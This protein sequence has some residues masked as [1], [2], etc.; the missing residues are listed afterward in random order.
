MFEYVFVSKEEE[1]LEAQR[2]FNE[3]ALWLKIDLSFQNFEEELASLRTMYAE[4]KGCILLCKHEKNPVACVAVRSKEK[5]IAELKRMYVQ[6]AF[7]K[8]GIGD[9]LLNMA[10]DFS[11]K[12]GYKKIRL[13]TLDT[14]IP[15][16]GLYEKNGF[17]KIPAYYFNPEP[18][19]VYFEKEL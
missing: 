9:V 10:I 6:S 12:A 19:A 13:D 8:R 2:L 3:Y 1:Y 18:N 15:A 14:M 7:Q 16:M 5:D 11:K 17:Y 4:P